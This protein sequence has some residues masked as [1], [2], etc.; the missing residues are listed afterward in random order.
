MPKVSVIVPVYNVAEYVEGCLNSL[1]AQ[2]EKD[3][4]II[5]V[6]DGSTDSSGQIVDE[7]ARKDKRI[8]VIHQ[9]NGGLS[10]A[11][12]TGLDQAIGEYVSFCDSDDYFHPEFFEKFIEIMTK[13]KADVV[14]GQ[15]VS[16]HQKY[17]IPFKPL[18]EKKARLIIVDNPFETF[19][20]KSMIATGVCRHLYRRSAI[21][22]LRFIEGIYFED[23]PFMTVLMNQ[24]RKVVVTDYKVHYYYSNPHSIMRT[25]FNE[26]KIMSYVHLIRYLN[27]YMQKE[28][29]ACREDVRRYVLNRRFKMMVNQ[30]VRK[31]KNIEKRKILF[32]LIQSETQKLYRENIIS[33]EGLKWH[34]RV[35]LFLLLHMK[36]STLARLWMTL[37]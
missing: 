15:I 11:R 21:K 34:H 25:S 28:N 35:A 24:V 3:I 17:P 2:T 27:E 18:D 9:K 4:E 22:N 33:Y 6:D 31:Q 29:P 12:N 23:V 19:L 13:T 30:A 36:T 7:T 37:V 20:K 16:T 26:A 32:D 8:K 10:A 5:C 1:M 14:C